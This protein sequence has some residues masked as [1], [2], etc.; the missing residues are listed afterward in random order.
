LFALVQ[1]NDPDP[2]VWFAIYILVALAL[3]ASIFVSL[4]MWAIYMAAAGLIL[5]AGFHAS[6][7]MEWLSS[8]NPGELFGEMSEDKYY[9]EGTR[10]FLG[11]LIALAA[12]VYLVAQNRDK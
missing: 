5:Y 2:Y 4:P 7:F 1:L 12:V 9:L 10:E 3:I 8:D 11:L 6:Y